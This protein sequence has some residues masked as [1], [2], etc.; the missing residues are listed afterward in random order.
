MVA[1]LAPTT[2]ASSVQPVSAAMACAPVRV[3]KETGFI[4]P[5][6]CSTTTRMLSAIALASLLH[7][8]VTAH[9]EPDS[10]DQI[11]APAR[12]EDVENNRVGVAAAHHHAEHGTED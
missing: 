8:F 4:F 5:W 12:K 2:A 10:E 6:R 11:E 3:S 1:A 9:D 7:Q